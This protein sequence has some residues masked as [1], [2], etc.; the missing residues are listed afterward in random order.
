MSVSTIATPTARE[1]TC[2]GES[3]PISRAVHYARMAAFYPQC[4]HCEHRHDAGHLPQQIVELPEPLLGGARPTRLES[5]GIRGAFLNE[6][7]RPLA[8]QYAA[9]FAAMLWERRP[10][11]MR[12][13]ADPVAPPR[14]RGPLVVVGQD[15]RPAAT[16]LVV[17]V[18][19]SLRRMGCQVVDVGTVSNPCFWFAVEHLEASGGV[20]VT[21]HGCGPAGIGLDFLEERAIPWARGG[22]L[23]RLQAVVADGARRTSRQGGSQRTFRVHIPYEAGLLR[24][25]H[26]LRP[27][28]IGLVCLSPT[29][30]PHLT[31]LLSG[32]T[33]RM[34]RMSAPVANDASRAMSL[35]LERLEEK[36]RDERLDAGLLL[37][38]DGQQCRVLD[39]RGIILPTAVLAV[40]LGERIIHESRSRTIVLDMGLG[41]A[42]ADQLSQRGGEVVASEG[43]TEAMARS[44]QS[45]GAAFGCDA[46]DRFWFGDCVPHC[47][48][49]S[50][51]ARV[52][53]LLSRN[54]GPASALRLA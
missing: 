16:E 50:T 28:Q 26:G 29:V 34:E 8:E 10:L 39:E 11:R 20:Y 44:M 25:F 45:A 6:L 1:Y 30:E 37:G 17:G 51:L 21:G 31:E 32:Q 23:D 46:H 40:R 53:Q 4:R 2:P 13:P 47:D 9:A 33:C 35:A 48:G 15:E 12:H 54:G 49:L 18:A 43:T 22:S 42:A 27:L 7:T 36:V 5:G 19:T 3:H 38:D 14:Q 52:L 41:T 24:H